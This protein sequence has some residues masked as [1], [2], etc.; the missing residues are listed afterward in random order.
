MATNG[1]A[2]SASEIEAGSI[3]PT[4]QELLAA[5][6]KQAAAAVKQAD[7]YVAGVAWCEMWTGLPVRRHSYRGH[8]VELWRIDDG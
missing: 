8:M 3:S 5:A 6:A 4:M 1:S 2:S 7:P